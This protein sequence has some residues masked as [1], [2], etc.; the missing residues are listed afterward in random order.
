MGILERLDISAGNFDYEV[1]K[2][3]RK[4]IQLD[5]IAAA[6]SDETDAT[7]VTANRNLVTSAD[8]AK[9]VILP[10]AGVEMAIVVVNTVAGEDLLVYPNSGEQIN[11][12]TATT[13]AFTVPGGTEVTFYCDVALHW[14]VRAGTVANTQDLTTGITAFATG[15]QASAIALTSE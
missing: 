13:G 10:V 8:G 7:A 11:A 4:L 1:K 12:L 6:G 14:Y 9:G 5:T 15:G 3:F 2:V